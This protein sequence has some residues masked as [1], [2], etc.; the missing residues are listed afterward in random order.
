MK[1]LVPV[2]WTEGMFLKP[3]H[4]QQSDLFQDCDRPFVQDLP[5]RLPL[6]PA[7]VPLHQVRIDRRGW[8]E[9]G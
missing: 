9:T 8:P 3:H 1:T 2:S 6:E 4:F 7:V 5:G